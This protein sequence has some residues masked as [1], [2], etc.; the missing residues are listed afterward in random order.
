MQNNTPKTFLET[1]LDTRNKIPKQINYYY[2]NNIVNMFFPVAKGELSQLR[3]S[4]QEM[5]NK[6]WIMCKNY[7]LRCKLFQGK[8]NNILLLGSTTDLFSASQSI[9]FL[10]FCSVPGN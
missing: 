9:V 4:T 7:A 1:D 6:T 5:N 3:Q 8:N 2:L 10:I